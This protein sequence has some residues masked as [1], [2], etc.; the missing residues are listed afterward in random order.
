MG[1]VRDEVGEAMHVVDTH[2]MEDILD[3]YAEFHEWH[4]GKRLRL[5]GH[6]IE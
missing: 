3:A 4:S 2:E 1:D 5:S 6:E